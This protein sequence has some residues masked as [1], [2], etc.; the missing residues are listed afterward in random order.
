MEC[1]FVEFPRYNRISKF[2]TLQRLAVEAPVEKVGVRIWRKWVEMWREKETLRRICD[3]RLHTFKIGQ[4]QI[5]EAFDNIS[6][7]FSVV[8]GF[9]GKYDRWS[10]NNR[11]ALAGKH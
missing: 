10:A 11:L 8:M 2:G 9:C 1:D 5:F 7:C 3:V 4:N 6:C